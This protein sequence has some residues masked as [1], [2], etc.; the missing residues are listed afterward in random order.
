MSGCSLLHFYSDVDKHLILTCS[1]F[2][3]ENSVDYALL[4]IVNTWGNMQ[5]CNLLETNLNETV[6]TGTLI[7]R[8]TAKNG[9][10]PVPVWPLVNTSPSTVWLDGKD[11]EAYK[12]Q[13][14]W[15][16]AR[17]SLFRDPVK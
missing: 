15:F 12:A 6:P 8:S 3:D 9:H 17:L 1:L 4:K 13:V 14:G 5:T 7:P 11:G 10:D 16:K 2:I